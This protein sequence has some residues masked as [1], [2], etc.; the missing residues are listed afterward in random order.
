MTVIIAGGGIGGLALALALEARGIGAQVFEASAEIRELGV[1]INILPHAIRELAGLGLL[2]RLD[3]AGI[4]TG[5]LI[6][7]TAR[8]QEILR[9]PRGL[10][11]G[12][13]V[14][15]FSI[16]RGRLQVL[17]LEAVRARLGAAAVATGHR[18]AAHER[19]PDGI[20][21][22]F[23]T[24]DGPVRVEGGALVAADGIHSAL[25]R[26]R[27]PEEGPP[28]WNGVVMWR[29]AAW[30]PAYLGGDSMIIAGGMSAKLVLYPIASDPAR[31]DE[32]LTNWVVCASV[33]EPGAPMPHREDWSRPGE[34]AEVMAHVEGKLAVDEID[35]PALIAATPEFYVYPMCDR[36]PLAAWSEGPVTLLGDAAHPMYPVGSNGASQAILDAVSLAR[37]LA[38]SPDPAA[39]FAAYEAERLPA[40]AA[41]V[42]ANR[43]GGPERVID[44]VEARAPE[45]FD[46]LDRVASAE[47]LTAIVG[48]YQRV[49]GFAAE[50]VNRAS[51]T[52]PA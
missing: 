52:Q 26:A 14:P 39:A 12:Y 16:H 30:A 32:R 8:G 46:D 29:G 10:G 38:E 19:T 6:Y 7:R 2:D 15:Q 31:P 21:A 41:I 42:E 34:I 9:Q 1:G 3:A 33:A 22:V 35:L 47:E 11:A 50:Q 40:T 27:H 37:H 4:R 51:G 48:Q 36:D 17:L 28:R 43:R 49:A 25:R 44:L 23:E 20:A 45:G 13:D 24:A 18:L 5:T